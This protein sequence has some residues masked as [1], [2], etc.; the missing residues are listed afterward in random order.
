VDQ[1]LKDMNAPLPFFS[2]IPDWLITTNPK[3]YKKLRK[4]IIKRN[5]K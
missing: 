5:Y 3:R 4:K 2:L 1:L